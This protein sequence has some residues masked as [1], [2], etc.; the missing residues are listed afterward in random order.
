MMPRPRVPHSGDARRRKPDGGYLLVEVLATM[1]ISAFVLSALFSM[2]F[3]TIRASERLDRRT[4]DTENITRVIAALSR[5]IEQAAPLRWA[6]P[7]AGF[8]FQG[9]TQDLLFARQTAAA[10]QA[11]DDRATLMQSRGDQLFLR[12]APLLPSDRGITDLSP[13]PASAMLDT[14]LRVRFAYFSRAENGVEALT[15]I[16]TDPAHMPVAIRVSMT[17]GDGILVASARIR[18]RVD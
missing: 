17:T 8:V 11:I 15:D 9:G 7:G 2:A 13:G 1:T 16:W 12:E 10:D 5:E 14:P 3:F 6:G 4:M 18:L